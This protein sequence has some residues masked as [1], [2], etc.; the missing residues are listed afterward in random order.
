MG[1]RPINIAEYSDFAQKMVVKADLPFEYHPCVIPNWDNTP[2]SGSRGSVLTN[3]MPE[4]YEEAL[5]DA[6]QRV[7]DLPRDHRI[8]FIKSWNEW[9]E[10]NYLEPDQEFGHQFL[11]ATRRGISA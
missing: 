2:R 3:P 4:V 7:Q 9:A 11:E 5:R 8:V 1:R 10:G 6:C